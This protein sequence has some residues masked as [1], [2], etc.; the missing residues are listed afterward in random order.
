MNRGIPTF[1]DSVFEVIM[2]NIVI[3]AVL[4]TVLTF[5]V[6]VGRLTAALVRPGGR[7]PSVTRHVLVTVTLLVVYRTMDNVTDAYLDMSGT[8]V[9]RIALIDAVLKTVSSQLETV[10][11]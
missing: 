11:A 3:P 8:Y 4:I 6:I 9:I 1:A 2:I 5:P 7:A 10:D